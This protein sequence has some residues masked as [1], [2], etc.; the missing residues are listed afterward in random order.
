MNQIEAEEWFA[1]SAAYLPW[2]I[3][4]LARPVADALAGWSLWDN[5]AAMVGLYRVARYGN[6]QIVDT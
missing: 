4:W 1:K 3:G 5:Q 2:F 6:V